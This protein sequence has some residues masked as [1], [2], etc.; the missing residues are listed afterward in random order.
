[1]KNIQEIP[2]WVKG[3]AVTATI[4]NLR[5]IGG[6]LFQSASF[7]YALLDS[8]L[9]VTA[10]G[11]LTMS[12]EAYNEWGNDD[13]YAYNYAAEKLNL[14]IT[15]DYV[16]PVIASSNEPILMT[17]NG[18]V[19]LSSINPTTKLEITPEPTVQDNLTVETDEAVEAPVADIEPEV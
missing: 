15:G 12:G 8:D 9:A 4:F 16:A 7:Y 1:M 11:N 3:Q 6:E 5:P 14:V 13:E 17:S 19:G 18:T 2:T 10:D